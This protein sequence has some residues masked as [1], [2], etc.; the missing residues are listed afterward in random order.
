MRDRDPRMIRFRNFWIKARPHYEAK[1]LH[2]VFD[3]I[4]ARLCSRF[5]RKW[6]ITPEHVRQYLNRRRTEGTNSRLLEM[7][8][9]T[10][11][12]LLEVAA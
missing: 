9:R 2:P 8:L 6:P 5:W 3:D 11:E 10:L 12:D 7:E 1:G 4:I